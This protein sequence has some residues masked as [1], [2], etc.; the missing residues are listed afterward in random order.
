MASWRSNACSLIPSPVLSAG[1]PAA[2]RR[3]GRVELT[4]EP[5][6]ERVAPFLVELAGVLR[7][8]ADHCF[9]A[10]VTAGRLAAGLRPRHRLDRSADRGLLRRSGNTRRRGGTDRVTVS[11]GG[12]G[13]RL[14][15][16]KSLR[17]ELPDERV[18]LAPGDALASERVGSALELAM[19]ALHVGEQRT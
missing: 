9:D 13:L 4:V 15:D 7:G 1:E 10:A 16:P 2:D 12:L 3:R 8:P 18:L 19:V 5:G 17:G 11:H 6:R 14:R